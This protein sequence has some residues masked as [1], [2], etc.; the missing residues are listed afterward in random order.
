LTE[1][2]LGCRFLNS[3]PLEEEAEALQRLSSPSQ[4]GF[5][6]SQHASTF[7]HALMLFPLLSSAQQSILV[8]TP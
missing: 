2:K 4:C 6:S 7:L 3:V 8:Q 1:K 5:E